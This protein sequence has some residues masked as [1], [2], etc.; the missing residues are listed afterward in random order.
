MSRGTK[1]TDKRRNAQSLK[2]RPPRLAPSPYVLIVCEGAKTEPKYFHSIRRGRRLSPELFTI[3]PG[4]ECGSHP[5][6]VVEYAKK[7]ARQ[8]R[9]GGTPYD[10]IWCVFDRDQHERIEDA[11]AKARAAKVRVAF[12]HPCFELWYL[13]HFQDQNAWIERDEVTRTLRTHIP[14]YDKA[15]DVY[16]V[17]MDGQACALERAARLDSQHSN[18]QGIPSNPSTTVYDLVNYLNGIGQ[19]QQFQS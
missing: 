18:V 5:T 19:A 4:D 3:V 17:L 1:G 13:L 7:R 6:C 12:S 15:S 14:G 16:G 10:Q 11:F 9:Q 8:A 2:R